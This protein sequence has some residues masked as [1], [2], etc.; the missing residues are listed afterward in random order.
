MP[1]Q[2]GFSFTMKLH[3]L[4]ENPNDYI[5]EPMTQEKFFHLWQLANDPKFE[6]DW[7]WIS[8]QKEFVKSVN[9]YNTDRI[10]QFKNLVTLAES[11]LIEYDSR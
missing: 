7:N 3:P 9:A 5:F 8:H 11:L 10:D 1:P 2:G 4:A 6:K